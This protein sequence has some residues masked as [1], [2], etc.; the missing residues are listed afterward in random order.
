MSAYSYTEQHD[1]VHVI[2]PANG[3]WN[4]A[5]KHWPHGRAAIIAFL[6]ALASTTQSGGVQS[7]EHRW[8]Y[9]DPLLSALTHHAPSQRFSV[10]N[11][12]ARLDS[13][14]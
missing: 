2:S 14:I 6:G 11:S 4:C 3:A 7:L 9:D 1:A 12:I 10:R 8:F 13:R 5:A